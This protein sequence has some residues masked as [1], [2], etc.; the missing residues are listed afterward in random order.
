MAAP[1]C[2]M[3]HEGLWEERQPLLPDANAA[4]IASALALADRG[5]LALQPRQRG[6]G[7]FCRSANQLPSAAALFTCAL[8]TVEENAWDQGKHPNPS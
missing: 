6:D 5:H 2:S 3:G 4:L 8:F 7:P 1:S